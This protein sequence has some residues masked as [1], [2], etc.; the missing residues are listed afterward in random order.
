[1]NP[2]HLT[3]ANQGFARAFG[4]SAKV[5]TPRDQAQQ[6]ENGRIEAEAELSWGIGDGLICLRALGLVRHD[7]SERHIGRVFWEP[8]WFRV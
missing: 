3:L 4:S 8:R 2:R 7:E 1:M 6:G 5:G